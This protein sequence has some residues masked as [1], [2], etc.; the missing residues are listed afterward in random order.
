MRRTTD[1]AQRTIMPLDLTHIP[2]LARN[3]GRVAEIVRVLARYGLAG[4]VRRL[5]P[6][7]VARWVSKA[8]P[9]PPPLPAETRVRLALTD[10]GVTFVKLGQ[11]LSTRRDLVGPALADE[12]AFLQDAV[13]ADPFAATKATVE[14]ELGAPL[15]ELFASFEETPLASA[16]IGQC[17]AATLHDGR[18]VVVKVQHPDLLP[19]VQA[20]LSILAELAD[21]AGRFLPDVRP[22]RP[23]AVVGEFRRLLL[24]ELD[25]RRELRHLQIFNRNFAADPHV[26]FPVPVQERSGPR[27]LTMTRLDGLPLSKAA[28]VLA[29]KP[30]G[31]ELA[32]AGARAFLDMIFRDG[33]FHADPHPGNV[34]V[35]PDGTIGLL[36]AGMVGRVD[37]RLRG[38]IERA[39]AAVAGQDADALTELIVQV[40][41]P[42]PGFDP[43]DLR[44]EVADQM[45]FY[46]GLPLDQFRLGPALDELNEAIRRYQL[47]LPPPLALLLKVLVMLEGTG[48]LV[49]PGFNLTEV[50]EPYGRAFVRRRMSPR[51]LLR[52]L[53]ASLAVWEELIEGLPRQARDWLRASHRRSLAVRLEH[54]HLEPSVNRLVLGML[55]SALFVGSSLLWAYKAEPL[56]WDVSLFGVLGCAV[57]GGLAVRLLRA[58]RRSGRLEE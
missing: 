53:T 7:A 47:A 32:A 25:F 54:H 5:D 31:Q 30:S 40:G 4:W 15:G 23:T 2:Q 45:A 43:A 12:L 34:L 48:R 16:S 26:R 38:Q 6:R 37:D 49:C 55:T 1:D 18:A 27:V 35:L 17:H 10:L 44:V 24:R 52:R 29:G 33:F 46:W 56:L 42:P 21:L 50:L 39:V 41:D 9:P 3:V 36:D 19:R 11:I 58:I 13:P 20:D 14:A 22:Y 8:P 51:R 57:S 28:A